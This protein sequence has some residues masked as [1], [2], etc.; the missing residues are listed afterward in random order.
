[1]IIENS[2]LEVLRTCEYFK[3]EKLNAS[4]SNNLYLSV[5]VTNDCQFN[6]PYCINSLT[7]K[8]LSLPLEK[9]KKNIKKAVDEFGIKKS[10][11][12]GGEP[13]LYPGLF[14]LIQFLKDDCNLR[15]VGLTTNG[16]KLNNMYYLCDLMKS[17]VD[18]VNISYHKHGQF[19]S[20]GDICD[21]YSIFC[22]KRKPGQKMRIN[23]NIWKGNHDN[24]QSLLSFIRDISKFCDE[25]RISN[26]IQ[27]DSFS[28]NSNT[29]AKAEKMYMTDKEY[30]VLFNQLLD[31]Y[32]PYYSIIYNPL[33][34]GFVKY[35]L[36]PTKVP[37]ILN[38][39]INSE[40]SNQVCEN[41]IGDRKIH[42]VKCLVTGD[43][44]LSWNTSNKIEL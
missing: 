29:V 16:M 39:N 14:E 33:A 18:F 34:L 26:I 27:K 24:I 38:W 37:I 2:S 3:N 22:E 42:T 5:V 30:E 7:D 31:T 41:N 12:L 25:I 28:V 19:L 9:G 4:V 15:R 1:M 36:I 11:I 40:V 17:G 8:S 35:Y 23:T 32:K 21:I 13:T 43:I 10:V 20:Y 6:C 44:S